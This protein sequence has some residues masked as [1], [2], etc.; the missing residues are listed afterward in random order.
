MCREPCP[1]KKGFYN[2][3]FFTKTLMIRKMERTFSCWCPI[4]WQ[5]IDYYTHRLHNLTTAQ[6]RFR[7]RVLFHSERPIR[8]PRSV[9]CIPVPK[10]ISAGRAGLA[11]TGLSRSAT[12]Q[13]AR[14]IIIPPGKPIQPKRESSECVGAAR[15]LTQNITGAMYQT[16][17]T[18]PMQKTTKESAPSLASTKELVP[19]EKAASPVGSYVA[20]PRGPTRQNQKQAQSI[21]SLI[22]YSFCPLPIK[23]LVLQ[24]STTRSY[25]ASVGN[26]NFTPP[27]WRPKFGESRRYR[28]LKKSAWGLGSL[29]VVIGVVVCAIVWPF[30]LASG[31]RAL[32]AP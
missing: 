7:V 8:D 12:L 10:A 30:M 9:H 31:T 15:F 1:I 23:K 29:V 20:P 32:M 17:N 18:K 6:K 24:K 14:H 4:H 25:S 16:M 3:N 22:A 11:R 19:K 21:S 26:V 5:N 27:E 2:L 13:Q 28:I